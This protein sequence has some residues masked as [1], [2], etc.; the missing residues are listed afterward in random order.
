[1][2]KF[3]LETLMK[4]TIIHCLTVILLASALSGCWILAAGGGGAY[5]GY[6]AK[7]EGYEL[8]SPITKDEQEDSE[9]SEK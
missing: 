2:R 6:K 7:E 4:I 5:G 1:M 8:Q 9:N 3:L